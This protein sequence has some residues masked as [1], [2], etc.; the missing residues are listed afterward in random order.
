[1]EYLSYGTMYTTL[2]YII[3]AQ[4]SLCLVYFIYRGNAH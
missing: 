3:F 2:N 1:M 4:F